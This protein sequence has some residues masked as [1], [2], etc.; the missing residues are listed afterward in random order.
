[1]PVQEFDENLEECGL[2]ELYQV[3]QQLPQ[4]EHLHAS[5]LKQ[6]KDRLEKLYRKV[7]DEFYQRKSLIERAIK[8]REKGYQ[9]TMPAL[10]LDELRDVLKSAGGEP[11][12]ATTM[13]ERF[14]IGCSYC[15]FLTTEKTFTE[16]LENARKLALRHKGADEK[17]TIFDRLA[18]RGVCNT[19]DIE[20]HCLGY[21]EYKK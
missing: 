4:T 2:E 21:K 15:G 5:K 3:P 19:W 7:P 16:A 9:R 14:T 20:G 18:Q 17:I 8:D 12:L 13:E 11:R 10:T 6:V 1:M